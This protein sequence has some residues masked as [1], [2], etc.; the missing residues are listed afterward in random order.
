MKKISIFLALLTLLFSCKKTRQKTAIVSLMLPQL[1]LLQ[2]NNLQ[3][4]NI[5]LLRKTRLIQD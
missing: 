1:E 5:L 2:I 3:I 4:A